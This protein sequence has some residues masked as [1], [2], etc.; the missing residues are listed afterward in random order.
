MSRAMLMTVLA[1][2]DG[3]D[4]AGGG[5]WYAGGMEWAMTHGISDGSNPEGVIT[6][7]Q[8]V[9]MLH[10]YADSPAAGSKALSFSDAQLVS[11]YARDSMCWAVENG[12]VSGYGNGL[13]APNGSA[14]RAE[15]AAVFKRYIELLNQKA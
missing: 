1:R 11:G 9:S 3:A 4:T 10:R 14:T 8:L 13:L 15:V 5:T 7:E 2:L 12:I 6:R